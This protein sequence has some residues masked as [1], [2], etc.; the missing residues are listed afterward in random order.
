[1]GV[2]PY[3]LLVPVLLPMVTG[4][5]V[6]GLRPKERR[7]REILVM[8]G[9]LAA[10]AVIGA[11]V[12]NRPGQPLVL[13]RFGS[14]MN[15]S[16]GLDGLSGVFACLIAVLW[17]L[18]ALYS[19]EYMKHE[20]KENKFFG[21]FSI[22]YGVVAGVA[23]SHS[24]ITL[25]FFYELM[26]LATL[27]LVMHAMDTRAIY[28]GKK[29]LLLSMAGAAMVFVSIISLHEYGTTL[30][31]TWGGVIPQGLSHVE[32]RH[33]YGAFILAFF[34]FG[35]KAAVVPFHSA[36]RCVGGPH[37]RIS[38]SARSGSGEGGRVCAD[39]GGVLVLRGRIPY[40]DKGAG[41]GS[42]R[43][44]HHHPLWLPQGPLH[45]ASETQA[46]LLH[47]EPAV[48]YPYGSHAYD[49]RGTGSRSD[50]YGMPRP[51]EDYPV[52]LRGSHPV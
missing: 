36:S 45:P 7:K 37:S 2:N 42:V 49:S 51:D 31:F 13:Y 11:L 26:T 48:L 35:V 52:L 19:F 38:P 43:L 24:L 5:A 3:Y 39:A 30:D 29:Y 1:M 27:P 25:Y 22:T 44:L 32:R 4:A 17:P 10:S 12:L 28:A 16:L 40:R 23:L 46:G 33:L 21:Y 41:S 6:L 20:G 9:I 50:P 34:G 47:C 14:R 18:T 15:I 8:G